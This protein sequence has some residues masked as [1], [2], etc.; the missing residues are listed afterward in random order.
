MT[1]FFRPWRASPRFKT[2]LA[3]WLPQIP[4]VMAVHSAK[5]AQGGVGAIFVL[6]FKSEQAR[7]DN[8]EKHQK[9]RS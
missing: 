2:Y 3:R 6:L 4:E 9:R 5:P 1:C 7:L 8:R